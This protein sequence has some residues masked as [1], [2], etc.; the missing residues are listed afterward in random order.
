[1]INH[2]P[3]FKCKYKLSKNDPE[4]TI[5]KIA[6]I[7]WHNTENKTGRED[8]IEEEDFIDRFGINIGAEIY[9]FY[10]NKGRYFIDGKED[11]MEAIIILD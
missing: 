9:V 6:F 8:F 7:E 5:S 11:C 4:F 3:R 2:I 1:M 10:H